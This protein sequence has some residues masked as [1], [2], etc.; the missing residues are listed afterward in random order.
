MSFL[1]FSR[2]VKTSGGKPVHW[3]RASMDGAP[4]RGAKPPLLREEEIEQQVEKVDDVHYGLFDT[5]RPKQKI[6]GRTYAEVM[7]GVVS[8]LYSLTADRI[9]IRAKDPKTGNFKILVYVEW[10]EA[11]MEYTKE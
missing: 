6:C 7:E 1:K 9:F 3:N 2:S 10:A 8:Q 5:S 11:F 4:F